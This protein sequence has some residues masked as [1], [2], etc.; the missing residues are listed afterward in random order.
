MARQSIGKAAAGTCE[1]GECLNHCFWIRQLCYRRRARDLHHCS[2]C[3]F[4]HEVASATLYQTVAMRR[5]QYLNPHMIFHCQYGICDLI[6]MWNCFTCCQSKFRFSNNR[7]ENGA[8]RNNIQ[9]STFYTEKLSIPTIIYSGHVLLK[10][11]VRKTTHRE[12]EGV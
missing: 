12:N 7:L 8:H 11:E 5:F 10:R 2:I 3:H 1:N 6:D 4:Q 9:R